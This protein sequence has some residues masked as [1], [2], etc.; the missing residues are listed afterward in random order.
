MNEQSK[1]RIEECVTL[2]ND[3]LMGDYRAFLGFVKKR[4]KA[5]TMVDSTSSAEA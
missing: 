5:R 4:A 2:V 3:V 1:F